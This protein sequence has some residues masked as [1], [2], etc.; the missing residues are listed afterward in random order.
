[1]H[2]DKGKETQ[3]QKNIQKEGEIEGGKEEESERQIRGWK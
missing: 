3:R 1:M 2:R